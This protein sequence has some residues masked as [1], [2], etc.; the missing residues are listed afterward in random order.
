MIRHCLNKSGKYLG[1][2]LWLVGKFPSLHIGENKQDFPRTKV[3]KWPSLFSS[4]SD[5]KPSAN[6]GPI[7]RLTY[8]CSGIKNSDGDDS[9]EP[10]GCWP[11]TGRVRFPPPLVP[12]LVLSPDSWINL[13]PKK[14]LN[15]FSLFSSSGAFFRSFIGGEMKVCVVR[16]AEGGRNNRSAVASFSNN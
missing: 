11:D 5:H 10:E 1:K 6:S 4:S 3:Q 8:I 13:V 7:C 16:F 12:S 15:S 2:D 9:D 14:P